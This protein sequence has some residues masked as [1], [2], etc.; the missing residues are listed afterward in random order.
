MKQKK[1][2][3]KQKNWKNIFKKIKKKNKDYKY[4]IK[5]IKTKRNKI[6]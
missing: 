6:F 1:F 5:K 2:K 3:D 4:K